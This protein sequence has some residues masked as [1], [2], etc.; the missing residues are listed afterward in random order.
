MPVR[1]YST[2]AEASWIGGASSFNQ[3]LRRTKLPTS[4][5][6]VTELLSLVEHDE[7]RLLIEAATD[8][9]TCELIAS[10]PTLSESQT[11]M[12]TRIK[13]FQRAWN[14]EMVRNY[15]E[16]IDHEPFYM[17]TGRLNV[18]KLAAALQSILA[19]RNEILVKEEHYNQTSDPIGATS[20]LGLRTFENYIVEFSKEK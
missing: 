14:K 8:I 1:T 3:K 12:A 5:L 15:Y 10:M 9:R 4:K 6:S 19:K 17:N 7:E 20:D 2:N 13:R 18:R 16:I 11:A